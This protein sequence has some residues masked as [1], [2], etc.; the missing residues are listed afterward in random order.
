MQFTLNRFFVRIVPSLGLVAAACVGIGTAVIAARA[1]D[2]PAGL[3]RAAF[4]PG[5]DRPGGAATSD[6]ALDRNAFSHASANMPFERELDFKIGNGF[7]KRIWV[8]APA[9]TQAADGLGPVFNAKACQRCHLKDGRGHPPEGNY[10]ED[11]AVSMFLRLSIPPRTEAERTALA[12]GRTNVIPEPTYG[13]QLQDFSVQGVPAEGRMVIAYTERT[14][15]L[16]D[17]TEV[18]LRAPSYSVTNLGYGPL[19]PDTMLSPRV[20]PPMIG[21]GLLEH[22]PEADILAAADPDDTDG[23]G[24]SGK[25]NRVWSH[26]RGETAL[27]RFGWKAGAPSIDEQTQS[28]FHGDI[29]IATPLF[30]DAYG[31]CTQAQDACRAAPS[32]A[33][34]QYDDLEAHGEVVDLVTFYSGNLAVPARRAP[35]DPTVLA[36]KKLFADAGCAACHTPRHETAAETAAAADQPW[37]GG[38][39]IWPYTDLLLHDMGEGLADH[40]PEGRA[41]GRE[42]RTPP[43][44][45]IGLTERV[46]GHTTFLHDGRARNLLEAILWHGGEAEAARR[47]VEA[48]TAREREALLAFLKSL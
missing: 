6:K 39:V 20:A 26:V 27:G 14:V 35:T 40:R 18:A 34:P 48:M 37:L 31:D 28:A 36:G 24:I 9:S 29:G 13:G 4:E 23:D 10:P 33:S 32:G 8:S 11:T 38:Q 5:E 45:G 44:W 1:T 7:F 17:G 3:E 47:R 25:A 30:P 22:V 21:L 12:E 2:G 42:W 16:A 41:T 15:T 46:N 43:L 19:H